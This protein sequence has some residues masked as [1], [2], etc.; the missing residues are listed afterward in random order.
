MWKQLLIFFY[1]LLVLLVA[2]FTRA[3]TS[4]APLIGQ[5]AASNK[6]CSLSY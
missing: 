4:D 1:C 2:G 5:L 6:F 3:E